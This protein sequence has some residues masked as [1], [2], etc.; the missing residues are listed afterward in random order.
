MPSQKAKKWC[1]QMLHR[2]VAYRL[3]ILHLALYTSSSLHQ[4]PVKPQ[5]V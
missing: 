2:H 3:E 5:K 1:A 4:A